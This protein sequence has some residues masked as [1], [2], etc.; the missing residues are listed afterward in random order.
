VFA[1]A[2]TRGQP[3]PLFGDG[4]IQRDF[5]HVSDICAGLASAMR[6]EGV[7]GE[8]INLGHH[9][10]ASV[11]E[12]VRLLERELGQLAT[13]DRRP[14]FSGDMPITCADLA[15][16]ERLLGYRP[17]VALA[18]GVRDFVAWFRGRA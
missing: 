13:I 5:T 3:I 15:K 7:A 1:T 11:A 2:I 12:L 9:Q 6:A 16:A 10:P 8:A 4:S 18:D 17:R 14:A